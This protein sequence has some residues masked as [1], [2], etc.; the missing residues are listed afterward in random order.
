M[1]I[2]ITAAAAN[3]IAE[4]IGEQSGYL[5]LKYDTEGCGCAVDGVAALWFVSEVEDT[6][7]A[8]DTNNRTIYLEKSKMVFF[9]EKMTIDFST[10]LNR[11]QLKSP[12]QILNGQL[13]FI[14]KENKD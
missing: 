14:I 4:K 13:S 2:T 8:I 5:K 3:K 10:S 9:D 12:Q 11:F 7:I 1:E 6:D